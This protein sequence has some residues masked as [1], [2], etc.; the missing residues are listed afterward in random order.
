MHSR[1]LALLLAGPAFAQ[2]VAAEWDTRGVIEQ[3]TA[4]LGRLKPAAAEI[5]PRDWVNRGAPEA[6]LAQHEAL[7]RELEYLE[8]AAA[9]FSRQPEKLSAGLDTLFRLQLAQSRL[10]SMLEGVRA[11]QNPRLADLI[12]SLGAEVQVAADRLRPILLD[13]AQVKEQEFAI[14]DREAQ[15]C[16]QALSR[17]PVAPRK[18]A[19]PA[20]PEPRP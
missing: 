17:Q 4:S 16:R 3:L 15:R 8:D 14:A 19:E 20:K 13:L 11:Y 5:N 10:Q 9:A 18:K 1:W 2:S 7:G 6:Y 12:Q